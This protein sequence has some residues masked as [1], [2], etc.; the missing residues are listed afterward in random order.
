MEKYEVEIK[1][2]LSRIIE[3]EADSYKNAMRL[4][5][6]KYVLGE[7]VLDSSDFK[8]VKIIPYDGEIDRGIKGR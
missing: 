5:E 2:E 8:G 1:E 6:A 7:I 3:I 4:A